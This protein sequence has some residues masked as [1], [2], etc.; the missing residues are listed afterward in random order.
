[1]TS[2]M[3]DSLKYKFIYDKKMNIDKIQ[4]LPYFDNFKC[5]KISSDTNIYPKYAKSVYLSIRV[6]EGYSPLIGQMMG[7]FRTNKDIPA[8]V[9]HLDFDFPYNEPIDDIIPLSITHLT[10]NAYFMQPIKDRIPLS[11]THLTFYGNN[12]LTEIKCLPSSITHL[13]LFFCLN[14][15]KHYIPPSTKY[16]NVT[17]YDR[18]IEDSVPDTVTHLTLYYPRAP[19]P[20]HISNSITHLTLNGCF[21]LSIIPL[22]AKYITFGHSYY[23][24]LSGKIPSTVEEIMIGECNINIH[25]YVTSNVKI[26]R[27]R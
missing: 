9:T 21:D 1:M 3:M 10:F 14:N 2:K 20:R 7:Y 24:S 15:A 8:F 25:D 6:D 12:D 26:T 19:M 13:T 5:V 16:L 17:Y 23:S 11:V 4:Y 18:S 27:I 22:S